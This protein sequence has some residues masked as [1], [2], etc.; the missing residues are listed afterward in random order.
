MNIPNSLIVKQVAGWFLIFGLLWGPFVAT[1]SVS[2]A[3]DFNTPSLWERLSSRDKM[4][5]ISMKSRL[6]S[7]SHKSKSF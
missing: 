6:E 1:E 7:R 3:N 5:A 2:G 4:L